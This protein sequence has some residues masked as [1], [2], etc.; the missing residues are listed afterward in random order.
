MD[1]LST[2]HHANGADQFASKHFALL[3]VDNKQRDTG[4]GSGESMRRRGAQTESAT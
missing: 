2:G 1:Y 4:F 3:H